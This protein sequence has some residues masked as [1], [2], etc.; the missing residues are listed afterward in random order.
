MPISLDDAVESLSRSAM[1]HRVDPAIQ[2]RLS[3]VQALLGEDLAWVEDALAKATAEG[4]EPA[5]HAARHLVARGGKRVRP[6]ALLLGAACFGPIQ[7]AAREL[8]VVCELV[9]S[10]T[11]LHDDVIDDGDERRGAPTSRRVWGNGISVLSGD[12]LLVH[13]LA[14]TLQHAPALMPTLV[15]TLQKL[16][17]GEIVQMRGRAELDVSPETYERVLQ[18]KT[19]SL[20][21]WAAESG[22]RLGGADASAQVKLA[23]FGEQLGIAFQLVDDTLDYSGVG[24]GKTLLADL[25]E[26]K[27][28]LP[29][30]LAIERMPELLGPVSRI[31][32]G[33]HEP[34]AQVSQ[35]VIESG[36]CEDVRR[37]ATEHTRRA[38]AAL[39]TVPECPARALLQGVAFE[40][41]SRAA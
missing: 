3:A 20:F 12:L 33:D 29:L 23:A 26:G 17:E 6:M 19:A 16:V 35:A 11:L 40:L 24:T 10:A 25:S 5:T 18:G 30:V 4:P 21:A 2:Q 31:H 27:L 14:R 7:P 36:A 13:A 22:A 15:L 41:A 9:H 34:V 8:A 28:T 37:R 1:V 39:E 38:V 32:A